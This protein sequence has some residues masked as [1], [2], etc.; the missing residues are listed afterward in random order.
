MTRLP[1]LLSVVGARPNFMKLAPV[2]RALAA[3]GE[4]R[5]VRH[6]VVHTGQHYDPEMSDAFF[7]DLQLPRPD[8]SLGVGSG[9]HAHQTA[10]VMQRLEPVLLA[11]QPDVVLVYGDVNS[12]VAAALVA[13]KL[14]I[15]VAHVEAGLRSRDRT[16]PEELNRIVTDH[17][18]DLLLAPSRDAIEN[19]VQEG[20]PADRVQFVG[21]VMIDALKAALPGARA[22]AMPRRHGLTNRTYTMVTLHR[23]NN[24]DDPDTLR[25]LLETLSLLAENGPVLFPVHPRTPAQIG[26]LN[27][28]ATAPGVRL[29]EPLPYLEMLGLVSD[30]GLVITDSGGLQE[31]TT[32][33]GVPCVTVRPTTERPITCAVGTNRLA[34]PRRAAIREAARAAIAGRPDT[35]PVLERWDGQ[36]GERIA[37]VLCDGARFD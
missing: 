31:E 26:R 37:A 2:A 30:A 33:L 18:A 22:L 12:T 7:R 29:L 16:M 17:L 25:E 21:N 24:V 32:W 6:V 3:R 23:P 1:S 34:P 19:L 28:K 8:H 13:A 5:G 14:H 15:K 4:T 11:E 20:I 10:A 9:S 35:P 36:T 27:G